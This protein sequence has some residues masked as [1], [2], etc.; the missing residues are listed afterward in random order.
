M[1]SNDEYVLQLLTERGYL[2]D[3]QVAMAKQ[4]GAQMRAA[5]AAS[6]QRSSAEMGALREA[7]TAGV[8]KIGNISIA[9]EGGEIDGMKYSSVDESK[10]NKQQKK[11]MEATDMVARTLGLDITVVSGAGNFGGA[12]VGNGKIYLNINS[13]M[14]LR[15][16]SKVIAAASLGHEIVHSLKDRAAAEYDAL[17]QRVIDSMSDKDLDR[18]VQEQLRTQ[19]DLT[20][21]GAVDEVVANACQTLLQNSKALQDLARENMSLA[22]RIQET[23]HE[24]VDKVKAAFAEVDYHDNLPI[25]RAVQAVEKDLDQL[26]KDFDNA[27]IAA[28]KNADAMAAANKNTAT[29]GGVQLQKW[30]GEK[31]Q[32][33]FIGY[34][35]N[36]ITV[37]ETAI[38]EK[39]RSLIERGKTTQ[40]TVEEVMAQ[41]GKAE[42]SQFGAARQYI[43]DTLSSIFGQ[44]SVFIS[45]NGTTVEAYLTKDGR[46][47]SAA[48]INSKV[49]AATL[50]KA[51]EI[52]TKAEYVFSSKYDDHS[53]TGKKYKGATW[54]YYVAVA[55]YG[56]FNIPVRFTMIDSAKDAREQ[57]YKIGIRTEDASLTN[58]EQN[59]LG[60]RSN[61]GE[62]SSDNRIAET[63]EEVKGP[64]QKQVMDQMT[65]PKQQAQVGPVDLRSYEAAKDA[66]GN[67]LFQVFAFEHDEPEYKKIL[68]D[69]GIMNS[70]EIDDLFRTVDNAMSIIKANLEE[71][72]YAWEADID[73][74]AFNPVKPN[75]DKLYK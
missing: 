16:Y 34:S 47:H 65:D 61:A 26:Q 23:I 3:A 36:N 56:R 14:N 4:I 9:T 41:E 52:I 27:L 29:E 49:K 63:G 17:R 12:Y 75:S 8:K 57:I 46:R 48:Y 35:Q 60:A 39:V 66:D 43:R 38:D 55:T 7:N 1:T 71:L 5:N 68:L 73:D 74:R 11:V 10:L 20:Y 22:E 6:I 33:K 40:I 72:D 25:F 24:F 37:G 59:N 2:T 31:L 64:I 30:T 50:F 13:G 18:L 45:D 32:R 28:K 42:W 54:D 67:S 53:T 69:A 15:G 44:D 21:D 51:H 19:P 62:A 70:R 58:R